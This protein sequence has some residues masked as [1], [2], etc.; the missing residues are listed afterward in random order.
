MISRQCLIGSIY[1]EILI[2]KLT[3]L[4]LPVSRE[5]NILNFQRREPGLILTGNRSHK[6]QLRVRMT[7]LKILPAATKIEDPMCPNYHPASQINK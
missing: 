2:T 5:A 4:G 1:Q 7:Q 6:L 3:I